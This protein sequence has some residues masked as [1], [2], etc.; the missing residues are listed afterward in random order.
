MADTL[1]SANVN[2]TDEPGI[3]SIQNKKWPF[4]SETTPG[5]K[6]VAH[7]ASVVKSKICLPPLHIKLGF[8]KKIFVKTKDKESEGFG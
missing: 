2:R 5:Q 6:N 8:I 7:S 4:H 1:N 3:A